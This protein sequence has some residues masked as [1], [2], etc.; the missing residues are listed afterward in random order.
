VDTRI[1]RE[2]SASALFV[3]FVKAIGDRS[4]NLGRNDHVNFV[5]FEP[6]PP[7]DVFSFLSQT[8]LSS[9]KYSLDVILSRS[10]L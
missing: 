3:T 2:E 9:L 7:Q 1:K 10:L 5:A 4:P 8:S 6:R